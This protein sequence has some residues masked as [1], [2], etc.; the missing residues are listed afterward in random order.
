MSRKR[1]NRIG[2][3]TL[4][5]VSSASSVWRLGEVDNFK[6]SSIWTPSYRSPT[7]G[8]ITTS[9]SYTVHTFLSGGSFTCYESLL[10]EYLIVGGGGGGGTGSSG[11]WEGAGGGGAGGMITGTTTAT[12]Q[13]YS[14]VVGPGGAVDNPGSNSSAFSL[15][16]IG[17]GRGGGQYVNGQGGNGGSGGGSEGYNGT[18]AGGTGTVGQ[19]NNGGTGPTAGSRPSVY[20]GNIGGGGGG[21][22]TSAGSTPSTPT[23]GA[24]GAVSGSPFL[25]HGSLRGRSR[26]RCAQPCLRV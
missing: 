26:A 6:R 18:K 10:V 23:G 1:G 11:G 3:Y 20:T 12:N 22:K 17:G 14:I 19:G 25:P 7:G 8:T 16:A 21:G 4:P 2:S 24:G 5:T 9:G 13:I 15:T